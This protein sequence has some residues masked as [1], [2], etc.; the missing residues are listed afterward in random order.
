M[1]ACVFNSLQMLTLCR[2]NIARQTG[3][4]MGDDGFVFDEASLDELGADLTDPALVTE[5]LAIKLEWLDE[6]EADTKAATVPINI[7][8]AAVHQL[9]EHGKKS[10]GGHPRD[11]LRKTW[12]KLGA[13]NRA[14]ERKAELVGTVV[15]GKKKTALE[16][17]L[18][19]AE[20]VSREFGPELGIGAGYLRRL[21]QSS[22]F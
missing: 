4:P 5:W 18:E 2:R 6:Y 17:E 10:E 8:R 7:L 3:R 19:A 16:A 1:I 11:G 15:N 12:L 22:D 21:M 20:E 13:I 9:L 14:R